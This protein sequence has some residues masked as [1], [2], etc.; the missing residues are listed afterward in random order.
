MNRYNDRA[1]APTRHET[2]AGDFRLS[3]TW[4]WLVLLAIGLFA[5]LLPYNATHAA[6][7]VRVVANV[8]PLD[9]TPIEA[10]VTV[11]DANG[12]PVT[13]LTADNFSILEDGA[14]QSSPTVTLPPSAPGSTAVT[15]AF[16]MDYSSST[17]GSVTEMEAA[18]ESLITNQMQADDFGAVVKFNSEVTMFPSTFTSNK[19]NLITAV[20]EPYV[21]TVSGSRMY[22]A[23]IR[24]FNRINTAAGTLPEGPRAVILLSDGRDNASNNTIDDVL[25]QIESNPTPIPV[26]TIGFGN[27]INTAVLNEIADASNGQSYTAADETELQ[28]IYETIADQLQ[29]E[30]VLSYSSS[31]T[32]CSVHTL[33]VRVDTPTAQTETVNFR[34]CTP[35]SSGGGGGGGGTIGL[36]DCV[37]LLGLGALVISRRRRTS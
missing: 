12:D 10:Y 29:N 11:T 35:A 15:L 37:I 4:H 24:A 16:V 2:L 20:N 21:P 5:G 1:Y 22:D 32:D 34:R 9:T 33:E 8:A 3:R 36:L 26:F 17:R 6:L 14:A 7:N 31:I 23:L 13:D 18:V 28:D 27:K 30:Y 25:A 19:T